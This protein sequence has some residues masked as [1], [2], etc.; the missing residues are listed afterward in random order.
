MSTEGV[1]V[2]TETENLGGGGEG[3]GRGRGR[4]REPSLQTIS[5]EVPLIVF[6]DLWDGKRVRASSTIQHLSV[7]GSRVYLTRLT[8]GYTS[9]ASCVQ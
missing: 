1:E 6:T 5:F 7:G 4:G 8:A 2:F 3:E 9:L